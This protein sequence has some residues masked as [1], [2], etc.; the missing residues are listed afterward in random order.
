MQAFTSRFRGNVPRAGAG[1][2]FLHQAMTGKAPF[3]REEFMRQLN[4]LPGACPA[5]E[6]TGG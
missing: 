1:L 2:A 3:R 4:E 5:P 6:E